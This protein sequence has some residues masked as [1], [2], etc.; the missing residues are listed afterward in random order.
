V[1]LL[2]QLD[3]ADDHL[4]RIERDRRLAALVEEVL[5]RARGAA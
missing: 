1:E 3:D 2:M 4:L 5:L